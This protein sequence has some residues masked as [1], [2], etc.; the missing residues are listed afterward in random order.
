MNSS[1]R[2]PGNLHPLIT[3]FLQNAWLMQEQSGSVLIC[4][5]VLKAAKRK[6]FLLP[7]PAAQPELDGLMHSFIRKNELFSVPKLN[8]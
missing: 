8:N 6:L 4:L 1:I 7:E 5:P 2:G 3:F